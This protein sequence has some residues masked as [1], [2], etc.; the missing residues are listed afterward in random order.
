MTPSC[1]DFMYFTMRNV[2][3]SDVH[4][5]V[6]APLHERGEPFHKNKALHHDVPRILK[7]GLAILMAPALAQLVSTVKW[8]LNQIN[9][10]Q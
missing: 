8:Q 10:S 3:V 2:P 9:A 6:R 5:N 7:T 4:L 1:V